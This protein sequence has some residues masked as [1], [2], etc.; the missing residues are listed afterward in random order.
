MFSKLLRPRQSTASRR[1]TFQ[2]QPTVV[3]E[4]KGSK[5][6]RT[7]KEIKRAFHLNALNKKDNYGRSDKNVRD[8]EKYKLYNENIAPIPVRAQDHIDLRAPPTS[9]ME[10]GVPVVKTRAVKHEPVLVNV[11]PNET[12]RSWH[13]EIVTPPPPHQLAAPQPPEGHRPFRQVQ[14]PRAKPATRSSRSRG[15]GSTLGTPNDNQRRSVTGNQAECR[16]P[17][18]QQPLPLL[19]PNAMPTGGPQV[20]QE[21]ETPE[22]EEDEE[23]APHDEGVQPPHPNPSLWFGQK[24]CTGIGPLNHPGANQL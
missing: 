10:G 23:S 6:I 15:E 11:R 9:W 24:V 1:T 19:I 22:D 17:A 2:S 5:L 18:P 14:G 16:P 20:S 12:I 8:N 13:G 7:L 21:T 3:E 4:K